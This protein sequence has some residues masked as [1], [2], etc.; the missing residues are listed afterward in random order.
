[1]HGQERCKGRRNEE[2]RSRESGAAHRRPGTGSRESPERVPRRSAVEGRGG[3]PQER[4]QFA[5]TP[6]SL[7]EGRSARNAPGHRERAG[8]GRRRRPEGGPI[9]RGDR[10]N[11]RDVMEGLMKNSSV[12]AAILF[13]ATLGA[14]GASA[15][16]QGDKPAVV[17]LDSA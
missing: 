9:R 11:S 4:S 8:N 14:C 1:P 3:D 17:R 15:Q 7:G 16:A 13:V 2:N 6:P 10:K 12:S 5:H